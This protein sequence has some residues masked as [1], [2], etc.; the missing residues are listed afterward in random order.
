MQTG[1][2][3]ESLHG[4]VQSM[5]VVSPKFGVGAVERRVSV[6]L[7]FLD[8]VRWRGCVSHHVLS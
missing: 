3:Y 7:G 5:S 2:T 1:E 4:T 8:T 6:G